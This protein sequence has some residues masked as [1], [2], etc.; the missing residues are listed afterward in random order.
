ML[1]LALSAIKYFRKGHLA[2]R[3]TIIILEIYHLSYIH[4]IFISHD[5]I[6]SI[7]N[8]EFEMPFC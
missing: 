3:K 5:F 1:F 6:T 4:V 8:A 7:D 2:L